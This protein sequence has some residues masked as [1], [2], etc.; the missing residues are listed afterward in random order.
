MD[1]AGVTSAVGKCTGLSRQWRECKQVLG[2]QGLVPVSE[3]DRK[4]RE[5]LP[6]QPGLAVGGGTSPYC[7]L[8]PG[9]YAGAWRTNLSVGERGSRQLLTPWGFYLV[10][11]Q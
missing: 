4:Y 11:H 10:W 8:S 5:N 3:P 2:T 1:S 9:R 7:K 6:S